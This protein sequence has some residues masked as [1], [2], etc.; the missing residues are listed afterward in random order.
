MKI[1]IRFIDII[2]S[3]VGIILA[4]PVIFII[5]CFSLI[6]MGRPVI[7]KQQRLGKNKK[8]F[9]LY[10]FRTMNLSTPCI[11]THMIGESSINRYGKVLRKYKLDEIPQLL[12]VLKG[13]MSFVGPRPNLPNQNSLIYH[14]DKLNVYCVL[15][16]ITGLSQVSGVDMENPEKLADLDCEMINNFNLKNYLKYILFTIL[17]KGRGDKVNKV[18]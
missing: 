13:N 15:P 4:T 7:F 17:G 6:H 8:P 11:S 18:K 10:K 5:Y 16:G 1:T 12:N 2:L 14:R 9:V 3:M